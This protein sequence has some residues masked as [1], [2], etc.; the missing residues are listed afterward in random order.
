MRR[1]HSNAVLVVTV[2]LLARLRK[3]RP[4]CDQHAV[5]DNRPPLTTPD[6]LVPGVP[7]RRYGA[8]MRG[9]ELA[10]PS[11][12]SSARRPSGSAAA[13]WRPTSASTRR[14][15][16]GPATVLAVLDG[17]PLGGLD[18]PEALGGV[19]AG[20][21]AKVVVA[22]GAGR[23]RRRWARRAPTGR[24]LAAGAVDGLPRS[25][26]WPPRWRRPAST[27]RPSAR[28]RSSIRSAAHVGAGV[29]AGVAGA[30]LGVGDGGRHAA[31]ARGDRP[32][33]PVD[34]AGLPGVRRR[35][36]SRSADTVERGRWDAGAVDR[37]RRCGPGPGCGRRP[38]RSASA[39]A[40]LAETIGYT[41]ERVVF[42][43][44]VAHHQG[45]AFDL[46]H[47]AARVHGAR[48]AVRD[49]AAAFDGEEP[50]AGVLGDPGVAGDDGGRVHL[51]TNLGIQLLGGHGFIV[52]HLAEKRFREARMLAMLAGARDAAELDVA[53]FVLDV[54]DPLAAGRRG[55]IELDP[56]TQEML[57]EV[58]AL[59]R[60]PHPADGPGGR[61]HAARRRRS[62]T[63]ST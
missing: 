47:A 56:R 55:V 53:A 44:P 63:S 4:G 22:R 1:R 43:K 3:L 36:P 40:A 29:G 59:G 33:E 20:V 57:E 62:T 32:A 2:A 41:T 31:P 23:R 61:P 52:D 51:A 10:R 15:G 49:A 30:A 58:R 17:F 37:A 26:T 12:R 13:S 9:F 8:R 39:G 11:W 42:G 54:D 6:R 21:L 5:L 38:S 16:A 35:R 28:S 34:G 46:A 24:A 50:D 27:A 25:A 60:T 18:L 45:N 7:G 14:P 48:L 19:G